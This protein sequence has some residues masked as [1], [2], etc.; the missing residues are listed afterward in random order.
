MAAPLL[1]AAEAARVVNLSS[2]TALWG[3]DLFLHYVASKGA[4]IAMTRA[5]ARELGGDGIA[6]NAVAPGLTETEATGPASAR[7]WEQYRQ[8]QLLQRRAVPDDIASVVAFLLSG[9]AAHVTGQ[10]LAV[11]G[12]MTLV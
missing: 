10:V 4:I 7:R 3:A 8:G 11:N 2:D 5:L 6:V 9:E 1:R 12:G